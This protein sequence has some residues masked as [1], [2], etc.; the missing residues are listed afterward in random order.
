MKMIRWVVVNVLVVAGL[1]CMPVMNAGAVDIQVYKGELR[2]LAPDQQARNSLLIQYRSKT[3]EVVRIGISGLVLTN[4]TTKELIRLDDRSASL[5]N[6]IDHDGYWNTD[7]SYDDLDLGVDN[8]RI[9]G[10]LTQYLIGSQRTRNF[11]VYLKP[12]SSSKP[13]DSTIDW[14]ISD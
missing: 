1:C 7:I 11:S 12:Q 8:Y 9:E 2:I 14:G 5:V 3:R 6:R 4:T 10:S 13:P